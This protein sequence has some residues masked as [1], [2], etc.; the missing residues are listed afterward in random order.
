MLQTAWSPANNSNEARAAAIQPFEPACLAY[1]ATYAPT[2]STKVP[3][4]W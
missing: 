2:R 1:P 3:W 4:T